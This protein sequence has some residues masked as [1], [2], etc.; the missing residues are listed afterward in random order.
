MFPVYHFSF[1]SPLARWIGCEK[2]LNISICFYL[3][4]CS[5]GLISLALDFLSVTVTV[6][7]TVTQ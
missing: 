5:L 1:L 6:T 4:Y 7:D 2:G 3:F